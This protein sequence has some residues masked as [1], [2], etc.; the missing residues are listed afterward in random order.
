MLRTL[1]NRIW[2]AD[3]QHERP[4]AHPTMPATTMHERRAELQALISTAPTDHRDLVERLTAGNVESANVHEHLAATVTTQHERRD[5]IIANWPHVVVELEQL[6]ALITGQPALAHWRP[7]RGRRGPPRP[8][9][10]PSSRSRCPGHDPGSYS[11]DFLGN[12]SHWD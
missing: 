12:F 11:E 1:R 4:P 5:W 9:R 7:D 2:L 3:R 10:H 8:A 6:N